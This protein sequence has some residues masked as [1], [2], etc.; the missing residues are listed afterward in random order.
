MPAYLIVVPLSY[1]IDSPMHDQV[2]AALPI[3]EAVED[4][5]GRAGIAVDARME[6]GR[7]LRDALTRLWSVEE[8]DR[9]IL[10]ASTNGNHG[11]GERDLAWALTHAPTE[12]LV[13]RP[14]PR[15]RHDRTASEIETGFHRAAL[16]RRPPARRRGALERRCGDRRDPGDRSA[17]DDRA[18]HQPWASCTCLRCC[19]SRWRSGSPT[20]WWSR[21]RACSRST[22]SSCRRCTR[23]RW[24]TRATGW[25]WRCSSSPPWSSA[26]RPRDRGGRAVAAEQRELET[27]T[28]AR[29]ATSLL[30]GGHP[31]RPAR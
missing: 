12:M 6:R 5:A 31:H 19:R 10:P 26:C 22:G 7:S 28:I 16:L 14:R 23:S 24:P 2:E 11:F 15:W 30:G 4:E 17:E 9:V 25:C 18:G 8:F 20:R 3:L 27:A 13:L 29:L 1:P 21:W